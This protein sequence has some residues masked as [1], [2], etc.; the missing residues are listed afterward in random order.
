MMRGHGK[1]VECLPAAR[2]Y[3]RASSFRNACSGHEGE[4][5][6]KGKEGCCSA[7]VLSLNKERERGQKVA[8]LPIPSLS[9]LILSAHS[10]NLQF[11]AKLLHADMPHNWSA[12]YLHPNSLRRIHHFILGV[13]R[14]A[15]AEMS[16]CASCKP[17]KGG[18]FRKI[19][20]Y[21]HLLA[22]SGTGCSTSLY[23]GVA[24]PRQSI[25]CA[26]DEH[27]KLSQT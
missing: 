17:R 8:R 14:H 6:R 20:G 11:P 13:D 5:R 3:L 15:H 21:E 18:A 12:G 9:A 24:N 1:G 16:S 22:A 2:S 23:F 27:F 4:G 19:R 25:D 26:N 7:A 10:L